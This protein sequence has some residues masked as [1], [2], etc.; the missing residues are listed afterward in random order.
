MEE[1]AWS[2]ESQL[3]GTNPD[4]PDSSSIPS[5]SLHTR[6]RDLILVSYNIRQKNNTNTNIQAGSNRLVIN[7]DN[8]EVIETMN[9]GRRLAGAA[10]AVFNDCYFYGL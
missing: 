3:G 7:S 8:L 4:A 6:L 2:G 1:D 10:A 5:P 9:N